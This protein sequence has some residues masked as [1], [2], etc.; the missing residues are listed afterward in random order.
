MKK[1]LFTVFLFLLL[2]IAYYNHATIQD[3][4]FINRGYVLDS[5]YLP[6]LIEFSRSH[7]IRIETLQNWIMAESSGREKAYNRRSGDKGLCQLHDV[8][9][10]K[11][12]YW[13]GQKKFSVWNGKDNLF[14]ALAYLSDLIA[15]HGVYYGFMAYNIGKSR[16]VN[17]NILN[18]GIEYV[19]RI[20]PEVKAEDKNY[21]TL[22]F[23]YVLIFREQILFDDRKRLI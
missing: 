5:R 16:I 12:K 7:D 1:Y 22:D 14:I 20:L 3:V 13:H 6:Q 23:K 18:C 8:E 2:L 17:G 15:D 11:N 19:K 21:I 9:Y 4:E 10:L